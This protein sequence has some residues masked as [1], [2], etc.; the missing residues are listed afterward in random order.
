MPNII[1]K[2]LK[3][4]EKQRRSQQKTIFFSQY[5]EDTSDSYVELTLVES[6]DCIVSGTSGS[7]VVP[8]E[9]IPNKR[10]FQNCIDIL[11]LKTRFR[12]KKINKYY[13]FQLFWNKKGLKTPNRP[14]TS[15]RP[16]FFGP[17]CGRF[18]DE[19]CNYKNVAKQEQSE[20][21]VYLVLI[22]H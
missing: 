17:E 15:N 21:R 8:N 22:A 16:R 4:D 5:S 14:H 3:I 6:D 2:H 20:S 12:T 10:F 19:D 11:C 1:S 7:E 13:Q 9:K 18:E